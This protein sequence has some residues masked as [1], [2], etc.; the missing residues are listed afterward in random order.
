MSWLV[1]WFEMKKKEFKKISFI[2]QL[3]LLNRKRKNKKTI[4][5]NLFWFKTNFKKQ[6][7]KCSNSFFDLKLENEFQKI[8]SF[9]NFDNEI[10]KWKKKKKIKIRFVFKS[11][12]ELYFLYTDLTSV[13]ISSIQFSVAFFDWKL[14]FTPIFNPI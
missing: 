4:F 13:Y 8:L 11:K 10:E 12:N 1:F 5:L 7:S 9:F 6:K 14:I 3:W 2:F